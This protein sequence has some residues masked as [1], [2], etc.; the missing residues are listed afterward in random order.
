MKNVIIITV[1][2]LILDVA[3]AQKKEIIPAD[4]GLKASV[5]VKKLCEFGE[6]SA[7]SKAEKKTID[8]LIKEFRLINM[9]V[10]IDTFRYKFY[11]LNN[12]AIY[13]NNYKIPIKAVFLGSPISDTVRFES[14]CMK[15]TDD[16]NRNKLF[17][18]VVLTTTS[19]NSVILE[20]YKPKAILI[21]DHNVL[22]KLRIDSSEKQTLT[23]IGQ[24]ESDWIE[25]YNIIAT[26]K[27]KFPVDSSIVITAHWDSDN[28]VGAGDNA[29]GVAALIELSRF[30]STKLKDLKYN[31]TF[32]ATGA[33]EPGLIGAIS[34]ILKYSRQLDKCLFNLNI[35]DISYTKPYIETSR[36]GLNRSGSDT[37]QTLTIVS[38]KKSR[39]YLFTSF[40]EILG[41]H[42]GILSTGKWLRYNFEKSMSTLGFDFQDAGC[43]SG[44][45]SR[46]FD[47][48]NIPY[49]SIT[50]I[51]PDT[52]TDNANT[53]D[54]VYNETFIE[55]INKNAKIAGKILLDI[56][57]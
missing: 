4:F 9:N 44:V 11:H 42:Q 33:E 8:Y 51:D 38:D 24:P 55:N 23:V 41:N 47:Y 16:D 10:E 7:G 14:Y 5:H 46:A 31:M 40:M 45:D 29:S 43:C 15:L 2:F 36:T 17:N 25:S 21:I 6:R 28:G 54:D 3:Q 57:K 50:S 1:L 35:D 19:V 12:R 48:V 13:L 53:P 18:K 22:D 30:F 37:T 49:I 56:N 26:Y 20:K 32:I 52:K 39:G 34:Y 27:Y